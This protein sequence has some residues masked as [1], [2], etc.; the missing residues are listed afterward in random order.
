MVKRVAICM[1]GAVS[2]YQPHSM[3]DRGAALKP[4]AIYTNK[5]YVNISAV[6]ESIQ[7]N[8]V[9][10]NP[11]FTFDFF[12]QGWNQDLAHSLISMYE[13]VRS[14]FEDNNTYKEEILSKC[15]TPQ[16]FA[17]PS[18]FLAM[19]KVLELKEAYEQEY[20]TYDIVILYRYDVLLWKNMDLR[21][22]LVRRHLYTSGFLAPWGGVG[23]FHF[24]MDFAH[25][26][27]MKACYDDLDAY[28]F[29]G[30][31]H[32]WLQQH[33]LRHGCSLQRDSILPYF[34]QDVLR[35]LHP[36]RTKSLLAFGY[37]LTMKDVDRS[38]TN[39]HI[40]FSEYTVW[41]GVLCALLLSLRYQTSYRSFL[42]Y[43]G[44][45]LVQFITVGFML[46]YYFPFERVGMFLLT[47]MGVEWC[48]A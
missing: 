38:K 6:Y 2:I 35:K 34:D 30:L 47:L 27:V 31:T 46:S 40:Y 17:V 14:L 13:P 26:Q 44:L 12:L 41:I 3:F 28:P 16:S 23:D 15:T 43:V 39:T 24:V 5:D 48:L 7:R 29:S 36:F 33:A 20:G 10:A 21:Q 8:I 32:H 37:G 25:S 1:R 18:Q 42:C 11:T 9:D 45:F 19:K 4:D 22:Y